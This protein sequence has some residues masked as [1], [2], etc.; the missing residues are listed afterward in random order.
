M[1]NFNSRSDVVQHLE[2]VYRGQYGEYK[3]Y[4]GQSF[5]FRNG[6]I[7]NKTL[8]V[9]NRN[10]RISGENLF[11]KVPEVYEGDTELE[12]N[13]VINALTEET[14]WYEEEFGHIAG[15]KMPPEEYTICDDPMDSGNKTVLISTEWIDNIQGD[16]FRLDSN[17][18]Y[19]YLINYPEFKDTL[20][21]FASK[22]IEL[23]NDGIYP[24]ITGTDNVAVY[25]E[26]GA[27]KIALIDRHIISINRFSTDKT[28]ARI[29]GG[30]DRLK[31]FL[32]NPLDWN[33]VKYLSKGEFV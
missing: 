1:K 32:K 25:L 21:L 23:A 29:N 20:V 18:L 27:P 2:S 3:W 14:K 16:I 4:A 31:N 10:N 28:K 15:L 12:L 30:I 9:R 5:V 24:D 6:D 17:K 11:I 33:N 19:E 22:V 8:L 13:K 7:A 26:K